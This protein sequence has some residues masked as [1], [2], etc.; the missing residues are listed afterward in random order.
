MTHAHLHPAVSSDA[1]IAFFKATVGESYVLTKPDDLT[2]WGCDWTK[3][4][5]PSPLCIVQPETTKE[6]SAL[7]A[8]C[9]KNELAVVPS[10]GRT[11]LCAGAVASQG[12]VVIS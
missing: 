11:G 3:V 6:V 9:H 7:L 10:G 8:Y 5:E 1:A 12:E 2:V 4:Y